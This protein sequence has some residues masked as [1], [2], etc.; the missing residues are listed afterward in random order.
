MISSLL[1]NL[2][3]KNSFLK[4]SILFAF[5]I[6]QQ[7]LGATHFKSKLGNYYFLIASIISINLFAEFS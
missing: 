2:H 3:S 6:I 5:L 1:Q 4:H 7:R